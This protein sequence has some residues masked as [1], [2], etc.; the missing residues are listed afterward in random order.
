MFWFTKMNNKSHH[1]SGFTLV[2]MLIAMAVTLLMMGALAQAFGYLGN[3]IRDSKANLELSNRTRA[4]SSLIRSDLAKAT[5]SVFGPKNDD[6]DH[7][8]YMVYYEGPLS[9]VS[10]I[11][12]G[13][14]P[15]T[16]EPTYLQESRFGDLDD[17]LAFTAYAEEGW[18]T[19]VVPRFVVEE[20]RDE[21]DDPS[22]DTNLNDY[23]PSSDPR[24]LEPVVITSKYAEIIYFLSPEYNTTGGEFTYDSVGNPVISDGLLDSSGAALAGAAGDNF[25]DKMRLHR[26]VLLI[27]PDLNLRNAIASPGQPIGSLAKYNY[28]AAPYSGSDPYIFME[29]DLWYGDTTGRKP[30][31]LDASQQ[32][33]AWQIGMA[34]V[35]QQCDLSVRRVLGG[36]GLPS[37]G[38]GAGAPLL[39]QHGSVAANSIDDLELPHNRFAHVRIAGEQLTST[40]IPGIRFTS[41]PLLATG[42]Q[43]PLLSKAVG[44]GTTSSAYL[45]SVGSTGVSTAVPA[46][47]GFLRPEFVLGQDL[48]HT[49]VPS[50]FWGAGRR[51]DDVIETNMLGFDLKIFDPNAPNIFWMGP[52]GAPGA[53]GIDDDGN[54]AYDDSFEMGAS[55]TD[56]SVITSDDPLFFDAIR[57]IATSGPP[58]L[59]ASRGGFVDLGYAISPGGAGRGIGALRKVPSAPVSGIVPGANRALVETA[60]SGFSVSNSPLYD[61]PADL[62]ESGRALAIG[63]SLGARA[64]RIYQPT[65]DTFTS[66]YE[67]DGYYQGNG[68]ATTMLDNGTTASIDFATSNNLHVVGTLWFQEH[69]NLR[70]FTDLAVNGVD[71]NIVINSTASPP[72]TA[73][74]GIDD[75]TERE[76]RAP[77]TTTFPSLK[78]QVRLLDK[79]GERIGQ[80][81]VLKN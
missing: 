37:N 26:R 24:A 4:I 21:L 74:V 6:R 38:A 8:G 69:A 43:L 30:A 48:S 47:N 5:V 53:S 57:D 63:T 23:V 45:P 12:L 9:D 13:S 3:S 17:Y 78:I 20:R 65:F 67:K 11:V 1:K 28:T 2:E 29:P 34:P 58:S 19:G 16:S 59:V 33:R 56:D 42:S 25:P 27:R 7:K 49:A 18:F 60:A 50:N 77:F 35:H 73:N 44:D 76:T 70:N 54:G 10:G 46:M 64:L 52:D 51:G 15:S 40:A 62:Y 66:G 31:I 80:A 72:Y 41:M 81:T 75:I 61:I 14:Q 79:S 68:R 22:G 39:Q 71:D 55:N 36:D 32:S